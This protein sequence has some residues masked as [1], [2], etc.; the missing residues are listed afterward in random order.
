MLSTI[1]FTEKEGVQVMMICQFRNGLLHT[2]QRIQGMNALVVEKSAHAGQCARAGRSIA[3]TRARARKFWTSKVTALGK[4]LSLLAFFN[5][6]FN[7][8][9]SW[10]NSMTTKISNRN[11]NGSISPRWRSTISLLWLL[12]RRLIWKQC[13]NGILGHVSPRSFTA[14]KLGLRRDKRP[15]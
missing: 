1:F 10:A 7:D 14:H 3:R 4:P 9:I 13:K 8:V 11:N 6:G 2:F 12:P 15:H 5:G